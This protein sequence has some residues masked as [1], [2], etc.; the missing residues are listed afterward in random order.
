MSAPTRQ[1][2][3][4]LALLVVPACGPIM[5]L[6]DALHPCRVGPMTPRGQ[7]KHDFWGNTYLEPYPD[8]PERPT[9]NSKPVSANGA[10]H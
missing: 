5:D 7:L 1:L 4:F 3:M 2:I 9:L 6:D 10:D 8:E